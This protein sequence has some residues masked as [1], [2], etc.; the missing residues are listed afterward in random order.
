MIYSYIRPIESPKWLLLKGKLQEAREMLHKLREVSNISS[1]LDELVFIYFYFFI[2]FY[3]SFSFF[4][5]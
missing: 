1:E 5:F 3:F 4:I 2:L